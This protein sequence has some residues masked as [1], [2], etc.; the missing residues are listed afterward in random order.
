[1]ISFKLNWKSKV[2]VAFNVVQVDLSETR[3]HYT[4]RLFEG[5]VSI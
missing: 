1:M 3:G 2:F 4:A 5:L